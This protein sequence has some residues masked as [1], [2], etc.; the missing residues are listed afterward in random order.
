MSES[1]TTPGA[2]PRPQAQSSAAS[3]LAAL[4]WPANLLAAA[5]GI[6]F[7]AHST[8]A[9][10]ELFDFE[11]SLLAQF[12]APDILLGVL[13]TTVFAALLATSNARA[14]VGLGRRWKRLHRLVWF[15]VPLALVHAVL[16]S[17]R[18][19]DHVEPPGTAL[20]GGLASQPAHRPATAG[21]G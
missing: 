12:A 2:V 15:A 8:V 10:L 3:G 9:V 4:I 1:A 13:A 7:V 11:R 20:L 17:L 5:L 18:Y 21:P 16:S 19:V 6:W 14:Q